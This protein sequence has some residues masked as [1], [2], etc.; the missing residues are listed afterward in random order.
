MKKLPIEERKVSTTFALS[1]MA[2]RMLDTMSDAMRS[3]RSGIVDA[4]IG[5]Y[6]QR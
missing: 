3:S 1:P 4:A 6:N 2:L 5:F